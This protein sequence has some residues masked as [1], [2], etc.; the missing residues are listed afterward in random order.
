M[1]CSRL[2]LLMKPVIYVDCFRF[3]YRSPTM[4]IWVY[5]PDRRTFFSNW[6]LSLTFDSI[7][8]RIKAQEQYVETATLLSVVSRA[9]RTARTTV[10]D[11]WNLNLYHARCWT[12]NRK[13]SRNLEAA[14]RWKGILNQNTVANANTVYNRGA[15]I[16]ALVKRKFIFSIPI[17]FFQK[18]QMKWRVRVVFNT[19]S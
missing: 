15:V 3:L 10:I 6:K 9:S 16:A 18:T 5:R 19:E 7:C 14:E 8:A 17:I 13:F 1:F 12:R 4:L 2:Q 11:I